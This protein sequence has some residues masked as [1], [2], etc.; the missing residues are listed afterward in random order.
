MNLMQIEWINLIPELIIFGIA[1][2]VLLG[3]LYLSANAKRILGV[4]SLLGILAA[5]FNLTSLYGVEATE[6]MG[7]FSIDLTATVLKG[8]LLATTALVVLATLR[9]RMTIGEGEF[10][11]MMLFSVLGTMFMASAND[12][13]MLFIALE[14]T[15]LPAYILVGSKKTAGS[16]EAALKYFLLGLVA[17][18]ILLYGMSLVYG[19]TGQ[20]NFTAIANALAG[21]AIQPLLLVGMVMIVVGLGFKVAAVPFHF[22]APDVYEGAPVPV[23]S[24]LAVGPKAGGFAALIHFFPVALAVAA[25]IWAGLFAILAVLSMLLGN[26]AALAQTQVRRL[27]GYSAVAHT[28][29]LLVGLAV[30]D[31]FG[32]TSLI[33]Y[34]LVY[35]LA[36]L[37][38]FLVILATTERGLGENVTD[39]AG[40]YKRAPML[41][42]AMAIF[43]FSLVGIPPFAGFMG[44]V[45]LFG[46]A[47]RGD[48]IWLA[49]IGVLNSVISFGYYVTVI[50]QMYLVNPPTNEG[51][52]VSKPLYLSIVLIM[53]AVVFLGVYPSA[54]LSII[55][56]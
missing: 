33:F 51:L 20:T 38:S 50:R 27:L 25:P 46:A 18:V 41:A 55:N 22:W 9:S 15:V 26:L 11:S 14:L 29:Y 37:G 10:F 36:A 53:A 47:V 12:L 54:F 34:F 19:L 28:G 24:F 6:F 17:S 49:V 43:L 52:P 32:Y 56:L 16:A 7:M 39:F 1:I 8:I 23:A 3:E 42:L 31:S 44:K 13:I 35:S 21:Q 40:L 2:V 45:Y 30:A 48:L 4:V 5:L